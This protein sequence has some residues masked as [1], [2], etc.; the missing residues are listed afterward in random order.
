MSEQTNTNQ[1]TDAERQL[2]AWREFGRS[3]R[4]A[5]RAKLPSGT[6]DLYG[7]GCGCPQCLEAG[8]LLQ[9]GG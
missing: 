3:L 8:R 2:A 9:Q 7:G 1:Q 6:L 4:Q 5:H